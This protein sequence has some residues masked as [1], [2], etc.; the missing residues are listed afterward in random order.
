MLP[1]ITHDD[2]LQVERDLCGRHLADFVKRSW[3]VVEPAT[4]LH[5]GWALDL[6]CEHLEAV[7][8]GDIRRLLINVP[9]G[10]MKSLL[11]NV[12]LP[13]WE[14]GPRKQSHLRYMGTA[15]SQTLAI[16]DSTKC[17]RLIQSRWYQE[18]WPI[19]LTGDQNAKTKFESAA[20]GFREAMP[21]TSLTGSRADRILIDDPHS[22]D[23]AESAVQR[24]A[25]VETFRTSVPS[26]VNNDESAIVIIM[27]RLHE[28]DVSAAAI[29]LGYDHLCL[30]M[31]YEPGKSRAV[32]GEDIRTREGELLF[33]ERFTDEAVTELETSLGEYAAAGQ[34]QQRPSPK[35]GG[36]FKPDM[37]QIEAAAPA[38]LQWVRGWDLAAT[39]KASADCTASVRMARDS[40]GLVWIDG[41]DNE[42]LGPER[43]EA[44]ILQRCQTDEATT[45][46]IPQDPGQAGKAQVA[47]LSRKLSGYSFRFGTESGDK[48]TRAQPFAAQVNAGNVRLVQCPQMRVFLDQLRSFRPSAAHDDMVD[49]A[50]RAYASLISQTRYTLDNL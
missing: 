1:V 10:M 43:V 13:A 45:A 6:I 30:P 31:R 42:R 17:R 20:T 50:S 5:W 14:W 47:N 22:V 26:R 25:T 19:E 7:A 16:R 15:H 34:L 37:I 44:L 11:V 49:A 4:P 9:P 3:H 35:E 12:F 28:E 33:P 40:S 8:S 36:L 48:F 24:E 23:S 2:I 46:D 21:F 39:A 41:I 27:Q 38:G 18:R 29:E 32:V